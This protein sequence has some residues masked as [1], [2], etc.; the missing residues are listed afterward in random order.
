[1]DEGA[2]LDVDTPELLEQARAKMR[3]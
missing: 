1:M 3:L 2:V